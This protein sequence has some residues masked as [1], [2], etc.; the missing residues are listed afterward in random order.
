[1]ALKD[2]K[3]EVVTETFN[4]RLHRRPYF[5]IQ[6]LSSGKRVPPG[7]TLKIEKHTV[8]PV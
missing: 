6:A 4:L 5:Q 7:S 2:G 1:M 8:K 3:R